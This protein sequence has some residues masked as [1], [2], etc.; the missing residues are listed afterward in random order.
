M[1]Y[2]TL[3]SNG[4]VL[5]RLTVQ[6][7]TR[8]ERQTEDTIQQMRGF[9]QQ[10]E[11]LL[12]DNDNQVI[13]NV[14]NPFYLDDE[15]DDLEP[16]IP[17]EE[18]SDE[19]VDPDAF[20]EYIG[21]KLMITHGDEKIQGTV[22]KR[23]KGDDGKPI[24][25]RD[26]NWMKDT[27][28]YEVEIAD[29]TTREFYANVLAE[30]MF[31]QVDTD[32]HEF[33]LLLEIV[34]HKKDGS[35]LTKEEGFLVTKSNRKVRKRTTR[36]WKLLVMWK[37][38]TTDWIPVSQLKESNPVEVAEY[39]RANK[40]DDEPAFAWWVR[41]VLKKRNRIIAKVKSR[42][43]RTTHKFGVELPKSVTEAF[44]IDKRTGTDHWRRAI[45]KEMSKIRG[46]GAFEP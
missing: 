36:G 9:T 15:D 30:N 35:A 5:S 16:A 2:W 39:A 20:D 37:S 42:Y 18:D 13:A 24:G 17:W 8:V 10:I 23:I 11:Q 25:K 26:N 19:Y 3:T 29:G 40:I 12:L 4:N 6:R 31:A 27:R 32:G 7:L 28:K 38:G 33:E 21:A 43:W 45:E 34:D 41:E 44:A 22:T 1:C 14:Q 46:M